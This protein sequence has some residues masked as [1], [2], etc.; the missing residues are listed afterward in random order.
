[1]KKVVTILCIFALTLSLFGCAGKPRYAENYSVGEYGDGWSIL[2]TDE[3]GVEEIAA[4]GKTEQPL[5]LEKGRFYFTAGGKLVSVNPDGRDR[6]ETAIG[7]MDETGI[8]TYVDEANFYCVEADS[9]RTCWRVS[10]AD[11]AD[12][13][14]VDIP[15]GFRPTD[16]A[17]L[18]QQIRQ[19]IS[20]EE[21]R[22]HLRSARAAMDSCGNLLWMDLE[23]LYYLRYSGAQMKVWNTCRIIV[24]L[25]PHGAE[26]QYINENLNLS[27]S[28]KTINK[29][30][31]LESYLSAVEAADTGR[32]VIDRAT[33][34]AKEFRIMYQASEYEACVAGNKATLT[35]IDPT[36]AATDANEKVPH[37][38]LAQV[39]GCDTMLTDSQGTACGN[40]TVFQLG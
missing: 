23:L 13:E 5:A 1:M 10:K 6:Q 26:L 3:D 40:L 31:S 9:T 11:P 19:M 34:G 27:V 36:G 8:I 37:L 30:L 18:L 32:L 24:Q 2:Y 20:A 22:I 15:Y 7:T 14:E 17:D 4:L 21:D 25:T 38:V 16:Y 33:D 28:D 29:M 12:H 39:G 35:Y